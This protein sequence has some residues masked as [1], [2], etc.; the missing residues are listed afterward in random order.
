MSKARKLV[1]GL[2]VLSMVALPMASLAA[3]E[4][5]PEKAPAPVEAT[6]PAPAQEAPAMK[7]APK[8]AKKVTKAK[9]HK[10]AMSAQEVK[11]IQEALNANGATLKVD[12]KFGKGTRN[13]LKKFQK[14]NGLKVTGKADKETM[15]KLSMEK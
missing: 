9:H 11:K 7:P 6:A 1:T 5:A 2:V 10:A 12:G 4:A 13:A 8:A 14:D 15:E 3:E